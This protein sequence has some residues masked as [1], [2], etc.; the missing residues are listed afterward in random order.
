MM[1]LHLR[2]LHGLVTVRLRIGVDTSD[3]RFAILER[4]RFS[5]L[6]H[7][8]SKQRSQT[9]PSGRPPLHPCFGEI[10]SLIKPPRSDAIPLMWVQQHYALQPKRWR[11]N[12]STEDV[13]RVTYGTTRS[14]Q[15]AASIFLKLDF[16]VAFPGEVNTNHRAPGVSPTDELSYTLMSN[17]MTGRLGA[18]SRPAVPLLNRQVRHLDNDLEKHFTSGAPLRAAK[19]EI[20]RAAAVNLISWIGLTCIV[21]EVANFYAYACTLASL[22]SNILF[23]Y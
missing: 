6:V 23:D 13:D 22:D 8:W 21:Y 2:R 16:Q 11:R 9:G 18:E 15:S 14:L 4:M 3:A 12:T 19:L 10:T 17:G 20:S 5:D 7:A 1:V